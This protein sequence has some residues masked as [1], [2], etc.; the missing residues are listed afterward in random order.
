MPPCDV[1]CRSVII[2]MEMKVII[3]TNITYFVKVVNRKMYMPI[4][5]YCPLA[6]FLTETMRLRSGGIPDDYD[7]KTIN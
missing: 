5:S 4:I 1:C 3:I 2:I 6:L 7:K